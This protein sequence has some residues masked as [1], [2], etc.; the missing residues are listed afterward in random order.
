MNM[1]S[2]VDINPGRKAKYVF[3]AVLPSDYDNTSKIEVE[4]PDRAN[5]P[6]LIKD[7]GVYLY[8]QRNVPTEE[9]DGTDNSE[10]HGLYES[11][12][13]EEHYNMDGLD[14]VLI[15]NH[16]SGRGDAEVILRADYD[17]QWLLWM[18][19]ERNGYLTYVEGDDKVGS[20]Y[21][22]TSGIE[23]KSDTSPELNGLYW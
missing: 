7:N 1:A 20:I 2:Y 14:Y 8:G 11:W 17:H 6:L 13:E 10:E 9:N 5:T 18:E 15:F 12:Y 23:F 19:D 21:F 22:G 4:F 16:T 3:R